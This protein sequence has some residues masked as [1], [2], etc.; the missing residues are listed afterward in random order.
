[1]ILPA[2]LPRHFYSETYVNNV[3]PLSPLVVCGNSG[4]LYLSALLTFSSSL[5]LLCL[6]G[7]SIIFLME[8]I[9]GTYG[10]F[11]RRHSNRYPHV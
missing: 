9:T 1:M 8:P 3:I 11:A 6:C 5:F 10:D 7:H 2:L 4:R